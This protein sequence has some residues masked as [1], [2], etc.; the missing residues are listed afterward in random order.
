MA[1]EILYAALG[2]KQFDLEQLHGEYDRLLRLLGE[3]V[4]GQIDATRVHVDLDRRQWGLLPPLA[5]HGALD[6]IPLADERP[7]GEEG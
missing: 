5:D 2:R 4:T 7:D 3:I 1:D 6:E